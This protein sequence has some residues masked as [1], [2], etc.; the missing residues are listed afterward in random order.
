VES[1]RLHVPSPFSPRGGGRESN[2]PGSSHPHYGFEGMSGSVAAFR[3]VTSVLSSGAVPERAKTCEADPARRLVRW[4]VKTCPVDHLLA[5]SL[6]I[7]R[8]SPDKSWTRKLEHRLGAT[9]SGRMPSIHAGGSSREVS[10]VWV[11]VI[12]QSS[13]ETANLS[14][15]NRAAPV[16]E[17]Q[18]ETRQSAPGLRPAACWTVRSGRACRATRDRLAFDLRVFVTD[19]A[20]QVTLLLRSSESRRR[21]R[22]RRPP[23]PGSGR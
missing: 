17:I 10:N 20:F 21:R 11:N 5:I 14:G 18:P 9:S 2:P 12:R 22:R 4:P 13:G 23:R 19:L 8:Y 15:V 3:P 6:T 7:T 16:K 1:R